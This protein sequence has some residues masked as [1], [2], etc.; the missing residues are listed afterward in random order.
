M[1]RWAIPDEAPPATW[2]EVSD[3]YRAWLKYVT[4][5]EIDGEVRAICCGAVPC[6]VTK[7]CLLLTPDNFGESFEGVIYLA[8]YYFNTRKGNVVLRCPTHVLEEYS[9]SPSRTD[10]H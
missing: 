1:Y 3:F 7:E 6:T 5:S 4:I 8:Q 2:L 9:Q 10:R